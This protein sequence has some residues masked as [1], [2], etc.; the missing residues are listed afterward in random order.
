MLTAITDFFETKRKISP[1]GIC[2]DTTNQANAEGILQ[3]A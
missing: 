1:L 3:V 2:K